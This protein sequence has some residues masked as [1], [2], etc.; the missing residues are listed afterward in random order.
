MLVPLTREKF[1]QLIPVVAT[2]PQYKYY[3]GKPSEFL[4]RVLI[5]V[6]GIVV[7]VIARAIF[8]EGAGLILFP[9]F[10]GAGLYWLWAPVFW[11]TRRNLETRRYRYSGF[12]QGRVLDAFVSEELIGSEETVNNRGELVIVENR[13]RCL[14]IEVGDDS[15][16]STRLQVPLR[17]AYK[18]IRRD[19]VAQMV[20]MS[21][22]PDLS[23]I[24]K[25]TDIY[26]PSQNLWVSDYPYLQTDMFEEVS[27]QLRPQEPPPR[28]SSRRRRP[29]MDL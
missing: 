13:E 16:F 8:G 5:S 10:V 26:I 3:W 28:R 2:F 18:A 27:R 14:N 25:V 11:A 12:W 21:H 1:E 7:V 23:R 29:A 19:Q 22:L 20:V 6:V 15:G 24:A 4:K 9:L 17:R